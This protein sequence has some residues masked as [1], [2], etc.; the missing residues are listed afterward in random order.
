[1]EHE[2]RA[3]RHRHSVRAP[4]LDLR[5]DE[6]GGRRQPQKPAGLPADDLQH[7]SRRLGAGCNGKADDVPPQRLDEPLLQLAFEERVQPDPVDAIGLL[8]VLPVVEQHPEELQG[9][10][11]VLD[12]CY[13]YRE[14]TSEAIRMLLPVAAFDVDLSIASFVAALDLGLRRN[15]AEVLN[16]PL[17]Q[18]RVFLHPKQRRLVEMHANGP[19]RVLGGAGTGKTVVAMHRAKHLVSKVFTGAGDRVLVTTFTRNLATDIYDNLRKICTPDELSRLEVAN[20]DAWAGNFLRARG[21]QPKLLFGDEADACWENALNVRPPDVALSPA[22]YRSEWEPVVQAQG[23]AS[24]DD[25]VRAPRL[26]RGT[27]LGRDLRRRIWPVFQEYR[28][29]LVERN[30][31]EFIDLVRDARQLA[32]QGRQVLPYRAVVVD[33]GQD[34]SPEAYRLIRA[35]VPPGPNDLFIVGDAHQRIYRYKTTLGHCG[36]DIRGRGRKLRL[37]YRTTDEIRRFAVRLLADR[38]IDDLDG[39]RDDQ[40]GYLSLTHGEAPL[41]KAFAT[42][43]EEYAFIVRE[44]R[45]LVDAGSQPESVVVAARTNTLMEEYERALREAGLTVFRLRRDAADAVDRPGVRVATLH[46]VKGLEFDH[47]FVAGATDGIIP[48]A[49]AIADD[50]D[51]ASREDAETAERALL[52]VGLT[53]AKKSATVTA[54]GRIS[55]L[56][57][58]PSEPS[59]G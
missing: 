59:R 35:L 51:P 44:I 22:F 38:A 18:W 31:R 17:A 46:R 40:K 1:V 9:R 25:Y 28:T 47:V 7:E 34:M 21:F 49:K 58:G 3:G 10:E 13:L 12:A 20:L 37:N 5:L 4:E 48:L 52:Y 8:Q 57:G 2:V 50:D 32:E 15:L 41:V 26:G 36:I 45:R 33:E 27:K 6:P 19:V 30:A 14:V 11:K 24:A 53:R 39:G 55:E 29:Q 16:A 56:V 43:A 54:A 23:I 42:V